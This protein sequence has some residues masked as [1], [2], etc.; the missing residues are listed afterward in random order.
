MPPGVARGRGRFSHVDLRKAWQSRGHRGR[1][2]QEGITLLRPTTLRL[3]LLVVFLAAGAYLGSLGLRHP[4][5]IPAALASSQGASATGS[6]A[7]ATRTPSSGSSQTS[8]GTS[9][10]S[11]GSS[12]T[13]SSSS[14]STSSSSTS[15]SSASSSSRGPLLS[16]TPYAAYAYEVYPATPSGQAVTAEDGFS[17]TVRRTSAGTVLLDVQSQFSGGPSLKKQVLATDRVYWVETSY[18]D[19]APGQDANLGDDGV[20]LTD[21]HGYITQK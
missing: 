8:T 3:G 11:S 14:T 6:A 4:G 9:S 12:T 16:S 10:A 7:T 19:D 2:R 5:L 15:S 1:N 20:V 21:A 17:V 13:P 18:G